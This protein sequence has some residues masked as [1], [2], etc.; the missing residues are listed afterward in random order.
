METRALETATSNVLA[1]A[2]NLARIADFLDLK[3]R[4][5]YWRGHADAMHKRISDQTYNA[6][7]GSFVASFGGTELDACLLLL[8]E[9]RRDRTRR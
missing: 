7:L 1:A 6:E 9:L 8:H 2:D 5:D 3:P 4:A